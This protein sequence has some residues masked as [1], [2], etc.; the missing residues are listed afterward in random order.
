MLSDLDLWRTRAHYHMISEEVDISLNDVKM[1]EKCKVNNGHPLQTDCISCLQR[2][3]SIEKYKT[4]NICLLR[5]FGI[6][7][8]I[9]FDGIHHGYEIADIY[10]DD[11]I[12]G[13]PLKI[14]IH[15]KSKTQDSYTNGL[16]R[17]CRKI[18]EL[19]AQ[20]FYSVFQHIIGQHHFD[21]IGIAIPNNISND[22]ICSMRDL[23]K[24]IG[25]SF[26]VIDK[27]EW[28]KISDLAR[29]AILFESETVENQ[30]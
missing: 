10:Y 16:G 8:H 23:L 24:R 13:T 18:K 14:G 6:P 11:S 22:V 21:V 17:S 4:D 19:Y 27:T 28:L 5:L 3:P 12:N 9:G 15:V 2:I 1:K 20:V 26:I 25:I 29:D 30:S 7:I